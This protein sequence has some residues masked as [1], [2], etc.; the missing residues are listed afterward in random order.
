MFL[1][2]CR[3]AGAAAVVFALVI[4]LTALG[5]PG[6]LLALAR[7]RVAAP[8]LGIMEAG[9]EEEPTY[10]VEFME[11]PPAAAP[12]APPEPSYTLAVTNASGL[13]PDLQRLLEMPWEPGKCPAVLICSTH[14]TESYRKDGENYT[15]SAAYRTTDTS[16][17][18]ISLGAEVERLLVQRGVRVY[19]DET[20]HDYPSYN[21]AYTHT[22]KAV[23]A[24]LK[25]HPEIGLVLDLHRD[26]AASGWG[27]LRTFA[28][29][30]GAESAQLMLVVGTNGSGLK[31]DGWEE[32]LSLALKLQFAL[33]RL[34]PGI[35]RP[36]NLRAQRFNQDLSP[37]ALL[38]EIGGAGNTR[39]EALTAAGVL[40]EAVAALLK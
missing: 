27:Q 30:N 23:Q 37:G 38:V 24:A 16:Y 28:N 31:H 29:V 10:R 4:R 26:A 1:Q 6:R 14:A 17:N 32:N 35:T 20:L 34:A 18:M 8:V 12:A 19:R 13:H 5:I 21:G 36:L 33:E 25:A 11:S 39:Q 2:K 9:R 15:E 7:E 3:R 22:R 40:A